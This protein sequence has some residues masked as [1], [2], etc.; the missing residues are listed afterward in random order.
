VDA[1]PVEHAHESAVAG[2]LQRLRPRVDPRRELRPLLGGVAVERPEGT[3]D[4][5]VVQ[6]AGGDPDARR[7]EVLERHPCGVDD[8][9]H[10]GLERHRPEAQHRQ[11]DHRMAGCPAGCH[12]GV[13][14][15]DD[16]V[17]LVV[18]VAELGGQPAQHLLLD[19]LED[20]TD[21][22]GDVEEPG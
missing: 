5:G 8:P 11:V 10:V 3:L 6:R 22:G 15:G 12:V 2:D 1:E 9:R 13:R 16:H 18:G 20:E 14:G 17:A 21:L 19:R 7:R 4:A